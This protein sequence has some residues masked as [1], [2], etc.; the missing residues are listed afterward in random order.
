MIYF[1]IEDSRFPFKPFDGEGRRTAPA[2][3]FGMFLPLYRLSSHSMTLCYRRF[4]SYLCFLQSQVV[5][6]FREFSSKL[7]FHHCPKGRR[8]WDSDLTAY[9]TVQQ[10]VL[11]PAKII[12]FPFGSAIIGAV[13][14]KPCR[15]KDTAVFRSLPYRFLMKKVPHRKDTAQLFRRFRIWDRISHILS[16]KSNYK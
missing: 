5:L 15:F 4:E 3:I 12:P 2:C 9:F 13:S 7:Y 11:I 1:Q 8:I 6:V 14:E 16:S 10:K